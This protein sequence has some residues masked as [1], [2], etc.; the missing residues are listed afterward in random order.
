GTETILIVEDEEGVRR[1]LLEMLSQQG[2]RVLVASS[3]PE[4]LD[5]CSQEHGPIDLLITDVI[6][7][8]MS[9]RELADHLRDCRPN[10]KVLFV[11]GYTDSA[12][13]HHGILEE[14]TVFLQKPFTP[15]QIAGKVREVLDER[16]GR[17]QTSARSAR[18]TSPD[19]I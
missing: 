12:I 3:G 9:G 8:K 6:M 18:L 11:S 13:V 2:Y 7:P 19:R 16:A 5:L 14:G 10:L 15:E 17:E 4:A 1:V